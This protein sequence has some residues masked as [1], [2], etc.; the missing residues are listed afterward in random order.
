MDEIED[1]LSRFR[2]WDP[3]FKANSPF[4]L[5]C[6]VAPPA[7][8]DHV[9][10]ADGK[11]PAELSHIWLHSATL[12]LFEDAEHKQWGMVLLSPLEIFPRTRQALVD[13]EPDIRPDDLVVAEFLGDQDLLM[14]CPSESPGRR[15][16]VSVRFD[17]R[18]EWP[19]VGPD[20]VSFLRSYYDHQGD[21]FWE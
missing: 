17:H 21:K 9:R 12:R 3:A 1:V 15:W 6:T 20:L 13:M 10:R 8:E 11:V 16:R 7:S 5:V 18:D 14:Y 2:G 4:R 19:A